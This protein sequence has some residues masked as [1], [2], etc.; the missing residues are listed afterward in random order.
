[1]QGNLLHK[2]IP[3]FLNLGFYSRKGFEKWWNEEIAKDET[4]QFF[5]RSKIVLEV[6]E[7]DGGTHVDQ[8]LHKDYYQLK[9]S[10]SQ[11][12]MYRKSSDQNFIDYSNSI[13]YIIRQ[14]AHETIVSCGYQYNYNPQDYYIGRTLN[15]V[16][17]IIEKTEE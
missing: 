15:M 10:N 14:I 17:L 7:S 2:Y 6:A 3:N 12:L 9:Y 16:G 5:N 4:D 1:M 8:D 13:P 11:K